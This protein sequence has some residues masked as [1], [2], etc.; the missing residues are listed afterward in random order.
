L[1]RHRL[2]VVPIEQCPPIR[3]LRDEWT[4]TRG[5]QAAWKSFHDTFLSYGAPPILSVR[6]AML[7]GNSG[8]D[9]REPCI[10]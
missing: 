4:A 5:G 3:K 7:V 8:S 9:L 6:K 2:T 1:I 10:E